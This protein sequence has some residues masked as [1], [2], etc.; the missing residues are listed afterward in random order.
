VYESDEERLARGIKKGISGKK[1]FLVLA[2]VA[3]L[4]LLV[5]G[6]FIAM[7]PNGTVG[8]KDR[9]GVVTDDILSPG[10]NLKD[11][12]VTVHELNTQTQQVV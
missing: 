12:L 11:P 5:G 10:F 7:V 9:M 3:I 4:V 2:V 1:W 6:S 8:V